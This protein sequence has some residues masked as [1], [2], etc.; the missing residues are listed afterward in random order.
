MNSKLEKFK[1]ALALQNIELAISDYSRYHYSY[2][3]LGKIRNIDEVEVGLN[4]DLAICTENN[5][6]CY[7]YFARGLTVEETE[8]NL[9]EQWYDEQN[10]K[11]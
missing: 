10:R 3:Y 2:R 1:L 9:M 7:R 6:E 8:N 5:Y 4:K 11:V